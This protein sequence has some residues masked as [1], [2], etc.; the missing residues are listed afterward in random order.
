VAPNAFHICSA[1]VT[2]IPGSRPRPLVGPSVLGRR[3]AA[4]T[5]AMAMAKAKATAEDADAD[6]ASPEEPRAEDAARTCCGCRFPLLLALLQLAL[7][8]AVTVVGFLMAGTSS[9]L[10]VRDT[11]FWAGIIVSIGWVRGA[12]AGR[13]SA[14]GTNSCMRPAVLT[15][16]L[17]AVRDTGTR[18]GGHRGL[19][20]FSRL[21]PRAWR[22]LGRGPTPGPLGGHTEHLSKDSSPPGLLLSLS[23]RPTSAPKQAA[24]SEVRL[25]WK[26]QSTPCG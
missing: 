20:P 10:L 5:A 16:L 8:I 6:A 19:P 13:R 12:S 17:G 3:T 4:A 2:R 25:C 14:G 26:V 1:S 24:Q 7:G 9:S 22:T 21:P 11:P 15:S 18:R 23:P